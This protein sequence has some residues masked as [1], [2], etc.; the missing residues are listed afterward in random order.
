MLN[1]AGTKAPV[2]VDQLYM[3]LNYAE[4]LRDEIDVI[5]L[6]EDTLLQDCR[7]SRLTGGLPVSLDINEGI[8][9]TQ[10]KPRSSQWWS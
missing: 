2:Y 1:E 10:S 3:N 7:S 5:F 6:S 9:D 8:H 4:T